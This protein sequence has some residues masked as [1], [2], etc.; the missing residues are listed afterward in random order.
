MV[1]LLSLL[2]FHVPV[3]GLDRFLHNITF[4]PAPPLPCIR[5]RCYSMEIE[6][7]GLIT[8]PSPELALGLISYFRPRNYNSD[9][10]NVKRIWGRCGIRPRSEFAWARIWSN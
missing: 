4:L 1:V 3:A 5:P 8:T 6:Q 9:L 2:G 10:N 7:V